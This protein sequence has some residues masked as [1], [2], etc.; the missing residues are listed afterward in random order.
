MVHDTAFSSFCHT[1]RHLL[2]YDGLVYMTCT[3]R[4]GRRVGHSSVLA[5]SA[6]ACRTSSFALCFVL[7]RPPA[8]SLCSSCLSSRKVAVCLQALFCAHCRAFPWV[9]LLAFVSHAYVCLP[10][11]CE[12]MRGP[13]FPIFL[14][15]VHLQDRSARPYPVQLLFVELPS[16]TLNRTPGS[17]N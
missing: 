8:R 4:Y 6:Q 5:R 7:S 10:H 1:R 9:C 15:T 2:S 3:P 13:A 14:L 16:G 11:R 17:L 12:G